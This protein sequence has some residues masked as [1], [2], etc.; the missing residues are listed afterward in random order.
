MSRLKGNR[1]FRSRQRRLAV[2][3]LGLRRLS[4]QHAEP[5]VLIRNRPAADAS[6]AMLSTSFR[7]MALL[8]AIFAFLRFL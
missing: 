2:A 5:G 1:L 4:L 7:K 6:R 8:I 3:V